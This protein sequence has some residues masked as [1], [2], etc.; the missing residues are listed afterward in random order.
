MLVNLV[1]NLA[2]LLLSS[3]SNPL[4]PTTETALFLLI[5]L[6]IFYGKG[7]SIAKEYVLASLSLPIVTF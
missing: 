5:N 3:K 6:I 7:Y 1:N 4:K 2:S